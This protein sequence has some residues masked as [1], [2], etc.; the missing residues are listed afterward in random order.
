MDAFST[1]TL[2]PFL[3]D[4]PAWKAR[5]NAIVQE[6]LREYL[7]KPE[8]SVADRGLLVGANLRARLREEAP[9]L[10]QHD[11]VAVDA[12]LRDLTRYNTTY[13]DDGLNVF[14]I[15]SVLRDYPRWGVS[16]QQVR[17]AFAPLAR[18]AN[19]D[20]REIPESVENR[21]RARSVPVE[22]KAQT[23]A[24]APFDLADLRGKIVLVDHW[25]T[26]CSSCIAAM[27]RISE[28]YQRYRERGFEVVSIAYDGRQQEGRVRRIERELD[29]QWTTVAG[30]GLWDG[31]ATKYGYGGFPQYMLLNR[32]GTLYA[33]SAEVDMGRGL[34]AL[35]DEMLAAED[36]AKRAPRPS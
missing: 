35:L 34:E 30:D 33:G 22:F 19:A 8:V 36:R 6:R 5:S 21:I 3:D 14:L 12:F 10:R 13:A 17:E 4:D 11:R 20:I 1:N 18:S 25:A 31:V 28:I 23:L 15:N 16:D 7:A 2:G 27:P 9:R 29:L 32:D 24:G 26:T